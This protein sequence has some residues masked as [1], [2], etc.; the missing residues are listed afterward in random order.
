MN[1]I[2]QQLPLI[3]H[4]TSDNFFL[5]AGP[6]V[7]ENETMP[8]E[9][10]SEIKKITDKLEIPFIF[11]ASYRKANRS[12]VYSFTGI[13]DEKG[14]EILAKVKERLHIPVLTDV[15]TEADAIMAAKY[16]D[17]LQI[18][19]FLCR[20]TDLLLAA[21]QTGKPVNV[22]K[23]QFVS[24]EAMQFA[25]EKI[26]STGNDKVMIT[27]RGTSFG[28]QDLIVDFCGIEAMKRNQCPVILDVTHSLQQP[29]QTSGITGG[30]RSMIETLAKAGIATGFDGIFLET[31]PYPDQALSDKTSMLPLNQLEELLSKLVKIH[32]A[33]K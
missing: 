11:K 9:I 15:H 29:N 30:K 8:L 7:I 21:A 17:V 33:L 28:Y 13:G 18:P 5:I 10:A 3:Q 4:A 25:V 6:C 14:L 19:A 2:A 23:G 24:P 32:K 12:S 20:Q 26:R 16:V 27:E 1:N 31:H 22:K